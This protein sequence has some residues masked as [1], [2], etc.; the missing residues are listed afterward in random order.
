MCSICLPSVLCLPFFLSLLFPLFTCGAV[1]SPILTC[2]RAD[3]IVPGNNHLEMLHR[4]LTHVMNNDNAEQTEYR[5]ACELLQ[6]L[7]LNCRGKVDQHLI[8]FF[9]PFMA[10]LNKTNSNITKVEFLDCLAACC[11]YNPALFVQML[12]ARG[13]TQGVMTMWF[14]MIPNLKRRKDK[15]LTILAFSSLLSLDATQLP[16]LVTGCFPDAVAHSAALCAELHEMGDEAD[17]D[18][19]DECP[20]GYAYAPEGGND[21]ELD[22]DEDEDAEGD[23]EYMQMLCQK[24]QSIENGND[25]EED[26]D[27]QDEWD[28]F[29]SDEG[30]TSAI[31]EIDALVF[32]RTALE[33]S[34]VGTNIVQVLAPE[35]QASIQQVFALAQQR[36]QQKANSP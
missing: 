33:G 6:A 17:D 31:D 16:Q 18:T 10:R 4:M 23:A 24:L 1:Y 35:R 26:E 34:A 20:E 22:S 7:L 11:Y 8:S 36:A 13:W 5:A 14:E 28:D 3:S 32:F 9:E 27:D 19:D 25:P 2:Y 15:R 29:C 30:G 21:D 12:E